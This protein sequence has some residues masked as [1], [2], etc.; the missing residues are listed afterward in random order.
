MNIINKLSDT[1]KKQSLFGK[2]FFGCIASLG[3]IL[4]ILCLVSSAFFTLASVFQNPTAPASSYYTPTPIVPPKPTIPSPL[5]GRV[6]V[7]IFSYSAS[8]QIYTMNADGSNIRQITF[9][10][11]PNFEPAWS[12]DGQKIAYVSESE[13]N[14]YQIYVMNKDGSNISQLTDNDLGGEHPDWS[15]DGT[16]IIFSAITHDDISPRAGRDIYIMNSDGSNIFRIDNPGD[17]E[18]PDWSPDGTKIVYQTG[19]GDIY[20]MNVDGSERLN[21]TNT[22]D[23][24]EGEPVWSPD[25]SKIAFGGCH[26]PSQ[27]SDIFIMNSDGSNRINLTNSPVDAL[28]PAWSPDGSKIVYICN[29]TLYVMEVNGKAATPLILDVDIDMIRYPAWTIQ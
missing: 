16:K 29:D 1:F 19:H 11:S 10:D 14:Y 12:P 3:L 2:L 7:T 22:P 6:A 15:P 24:S 17:D 21:L 18:N 27:I 13:D 25:G 5:V 28:F 4:C 8:S 20:V 26:N 9:G 23:C